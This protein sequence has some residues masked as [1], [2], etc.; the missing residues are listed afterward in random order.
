MGLMAFHPSSALRPARN[1]PPADLE[2]LAAR[3]GELCGVTL[4]ELASAFGEGAP[5][6]GVRTKGKVGELLERALGATGGSQAELDFPALRVELKTVPLDRRGRPR[7]STFVCTVQLLEADRAEWEESWLRTKLS[8][9]LWVPIHDH[10]SDPS[11]RS[12]GRPWFWRPTAPQDRALRED[13][14]ELMG[15]IGVGGIEAVT[16]HLGRWLQIRPKAASGRSRTVAFGAEGERIYTVPRGFYL[17]S[18]FTAALL[19][20]PEATP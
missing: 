20:D 7:E 4:R 3:A 9:V 14:E 1:P 16:A 11:S 12:I 17:R 13:F 6:T 5:R 2:E 19:A 10:D 18:R 15:T 8:H